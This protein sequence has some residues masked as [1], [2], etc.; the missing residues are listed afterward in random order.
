MVIPLV[1]GVDGSEASLEA[2][3]WAAGEAVRH[4]VPLHLVHAAAP[5]H[6]AYELIASASERARK[7]APLV[8]LSSEVLSGDAVSALIGKGRNA[9]ALV[10]GSRGLGGL[11]GLLLGSVSLAV[12]AHADCPVVVVRDGA[13][14]GNARFGNVVVGVEDGEGSGTAVRFAFREAHVRRCRLVAVHAWNAP[15][16]ALAEPPPLSGYSTQAHRRPPAQVLD[17][18]LRG[19][20]ERYPDVSLSRR[21][22]EGSARQALLNAAARADLLVVGARRR[23][24]HTGLQLGLVNHA[25]LHHAPCPAAVV[26]QI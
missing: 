6:E 18:A 12:A 1:A 26:P 5:D 21:V 20:A 17:D 15:L 13:E 19:A 10:L 22:I 25:V 16:G 9:F 11:A 14:Y 8:R 2:V 24:G 3:D 23:H 7:V 4:D